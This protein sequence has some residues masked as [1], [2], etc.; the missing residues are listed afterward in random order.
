MIFGTVL[1]A[2]V[3]D[4]VDIFSTRTTGWYLPAGRTFPDIA[5]LFPPDVNRQDQTHAW[6]TPIMSIDNPLNYGPIRPNHLLMRSWVL[7]V[8]DGPRPATPCQGE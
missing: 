1:T 7:A 8:A 4:R 2:P 6:L 3:S 5:L